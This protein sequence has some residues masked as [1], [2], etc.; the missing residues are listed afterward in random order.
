M[1]CAFRLPLLVITA[2]MLNSGLSATEPLSTRERE[3]LPPRAANKVV[4]QDIL[5]VLRPLKQIQSG[6]LRRLRDLGLT[7]KA[8]ETEFSGLCRR[9]VVTLFYAPTAKSERYEDTP[10]APYGLE[11][12]PYFHIV[13]MPREEERY[14][15][16]TLREKQ[17]RCSAADEAEQSNWYAAS[18]AHVAV[19]GAR[20][21]EATLA[22]VRSGALKAEPCSQFDTRVMTCEA[23]ILNNA[24]IDTIDEISS[25]H[26]EGPIACYV[27]IVGNDT[28]LT[29]KAEM[30]GDG[31][32]PKRIISVAMEQFIV[33]T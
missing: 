33:V 18:N 20:V 19:A 29:I 8:Y 4:H 14:D 21:L 27:V 5:S 30:N 32:T 13:T 23:V 17:R 6:M 10:I 16:L 9:D 11:A 1:R 2:T 28:E 7:T 31:L 22:A 12:S 26:G 24:R 15:E 3:A 25:C